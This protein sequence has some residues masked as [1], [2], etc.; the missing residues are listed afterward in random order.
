ML[1]WDLGSNSLG[2]GRG[3]IGSLIASVIASS[4]STSV[5]RSQATFCRPD[6]WGRAAMLKLASYTAVLSEAWAKLREW[7]FMAGKGRLLLSGSI[8]RASL[9]AAV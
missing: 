5:N 8:V 6:S 7:A 2:G 3:K 1:P 9:K 4:N